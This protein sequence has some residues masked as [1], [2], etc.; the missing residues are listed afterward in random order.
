MNKIN[1]QYPS[2]EQVTGKYLGYAGR[3]AK[4]TSTGELSFEE[5]LKGKINTDSGLKFSKHASERLAQRDISLT[6]E[7]MNRLEN[8]TQKACEKGISESLVLMDQLAFIVN[9]KNQTVVTAMD[10]TQADENVY[11]NIDGA[12]IV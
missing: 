5:V 2:I 7:Q 4:E 11:T 9:I 12:V 6:D 10:S 3:T 8:A 1:G